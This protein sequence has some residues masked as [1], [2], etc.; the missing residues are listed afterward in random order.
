MG[1]GRKLLVTGGRGFIGSWLLAELQGQGWEV[2]VLDIRSVGKELSGVEYFNCDLLDI[3]KLGEVVEQVRPQVVIHLAAKTGLKVVPRGSP[4]FSTNTKG[5]Q[6]LMDVLERCGS[7]R[8][9]IYTSTKYVFRG[10]GSAQPRVYEPNTSYGESK[11]AMEEMIW[12]RDGACPEW[13]IVRPTTIW[14]PGMSPHY[15]RFVK[16]VAKGWFVYFGRKEVRKDFGFVGNVAFQLVRLIEAEAP[17]VHRG[18]FY[19]GDYETI[20]IRKWAEGFRK[21]FR[22]RKIFTVPKGIVIVGAWVGDLLVYCGKRKF[23]LTSFRYRNLTEDDLCDMGPTRDVCGS[24]PY[25]FDEAIADTG[26]WMK[27]KM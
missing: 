6:N 9:V 15:C 7:V 20:T 8:R 26:K 16:L 21:Y 12:E 24:L 18:I 4:H 19:L 27:T 3:A 23:L 10:K 13:M 1:N 17:K 25:T 5:T 14:G 2:S 11:V 22:A